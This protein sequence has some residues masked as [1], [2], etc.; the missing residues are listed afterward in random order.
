MKYRPDEISHATLAAENSC[1]TL[2]QIAADGELLIP[3]WTSLRKHSRNLQFV[4]KIKAIPSM[5][6]VIKQ[7]LVMQ[8]GQGYSGSNSTGFWAYEN[9]Q[10]TT[11]GLEIAKVAQSLGNLT[12]FQQLVRSLLWLSP[13]PR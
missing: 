13:D 3:L 7:L 12:V 1:Y 10:S 9:I 11:N 5:P 6:L 4:P 8:Q 2:T